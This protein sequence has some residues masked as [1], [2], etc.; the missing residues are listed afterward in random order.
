MLPFILTGVGIASLITAYLT[1]GFGLWSD[2]SSEKYLAILG[3]SGAGKTRLQYYFRGKHYVEGES[4]TG[5]FGKELGQ[6]KITE[7]KRTIVIK[8]G[9]DIEGTLN[10]LK[11]YTTSEINKADIIFFLFDMRNLLSQKEKDNV[12]GY[13]DFVFVKNTLKKKIVLLGTHCDESKGF[14]AS[15][16]F[17]TQVEEIFSSYLSDTYTDSKNHIEEILLVN[18]K[19]DKDLRLIK[20]KLFK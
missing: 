5:A 10:G 4:I 15:K 16:L 20:Q 7:G 18:L 9:H 1:D 17:R 14:N 2:D 12:L 3:L 11:D 19:S 8:K 13:F 6:A